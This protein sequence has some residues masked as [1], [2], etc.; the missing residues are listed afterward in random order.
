MPASD[1]NWN[2]MFSAECPEAAI[3]LELLLMMISYTSCG[4][5]E[6]SPEKGGGPGSAQV[7]KWF[8]MAPLSAQG[9]PYGSDG[10]ESA[11]DVEDPGYSPGVWKIPGER[12]MAAHFGLLAWRIPRTEKPG[13]AT[14]CGAAG[15]QTRLR[16]VLPSQPKAGASC[17]APVTPA[18]LTVHFILTSNSCG[19]G[20]E[21]TK[22]PRL[23]LFLYLNTF[24]PQH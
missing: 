16:A 15:S 4:Q 9:F 20:R 24:Q 12:G 13:R 5:G 11:C 17:Q 10:R 21:F 14:A 23:T 18:L 3:S 6:L 7:R 22:L 8:L 2:P 1:G 19:E